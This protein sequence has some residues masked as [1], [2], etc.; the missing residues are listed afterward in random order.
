[1][2][3]PASLLLGWIEGEIKKSSWIRGVDFDPRVEPLV[4]PPSAK[5]LK[6]GEPLV[7]ESPNVIRDYRFEIYIYL[8]GIKKVTLETGHDDMI[9]EVQDRFGGDEVDLPF[10]GVRPNHNNRIAFRVEDVVFLGK[11]VKTNQIVYLINMT[12]PVAP[13]LFG[14]CG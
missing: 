13:G 14:I 6:V 11:N 2:A 7:E 3:S 4:Q 5:V 12:L 9:K 8:S 10:R 1:M